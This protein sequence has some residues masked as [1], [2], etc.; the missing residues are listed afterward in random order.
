MDTTKTV[1]NPAT[2]D[3]HLIDCQTGLETVPEKS[4]EEKFQDFLLDLSEDSAID[5]IVT[6][7]D[8]RI[9][10]E[11]IS[12]YLQEYYATHQLAEDFYDLSELYVALNRHLAIRT[13]QLE[14]SMKQT[15]TLIS[16]VKIYENLL[17]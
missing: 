5:F 7:D 17:K 2:G 6:L 1:Y 4:E 12:L 15:D 3:D 13:E 11:K 9:P 10:K 14:Q 8:L 16:T